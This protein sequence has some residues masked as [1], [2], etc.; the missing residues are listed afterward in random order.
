MLAHVYSLFLRNLLINLEVKDWSWWPVLPFPQASGLKLL[1]YK[2]E[3][4]ERRQLSAGNLPECLSMLSSVL[5]LPSWLCW[6]VWKCPLWRRKHTIMFM[7]CL[8]DG[9][10][11]T[12]CS[13]FYPFFLPLWE[14]FCSSKNIQMWYFSFGIWGGYFN[15]VLWPFVIVIVVGSSRL[16]Y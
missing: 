4:L 3:F 8:S 9:N 13:Q 12:P 2:I 7:Q 1:F 15:F 16:C 14:W 6:V 11:M 10:R 5:V